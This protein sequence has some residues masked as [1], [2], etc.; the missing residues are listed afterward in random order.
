M[1]SNLNGSQPLSPQSEIATEHRITVMEMHAEHHSQQL[2][3]HHDRISYLERAVQGL[4]YATSILAGIKS[5]TLLDL[6]SKVGTK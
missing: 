6:L 1:A 4:I 2:V 3:Q 5:D